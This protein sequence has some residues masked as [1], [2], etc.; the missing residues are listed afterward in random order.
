MLIKEFKEKCKEEYRIH[1]I[2][3]D[4]LVDKYNKLK[5]EQEEFGNKYHPVITFHFFKN[6]TLNCPNC[7]KELNK[8]KLTN[9]EHNM[10][11]IYDCPCGYEY[12]W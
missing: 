1:S 11:S 5:K 3:R 9:N 12:A 4:I 2:Q 8:H 10:N 7:K 6:A